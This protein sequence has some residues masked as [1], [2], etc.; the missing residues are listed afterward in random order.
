MLK[1]TVT[2]IDFNDVKQEETLYFNISKS[3]LLENLDI[4]DQITEIQKSFEG[5]ERE[6]TT[7]EKRA[8]LEL[9]KRVIRISYGERS[10]DGKRFNQKPEVW[11]AFVESAAYDEFLI[12]LFTNV[13]EA[14]A[15]ILGV[16]PA[17]LREQAAAK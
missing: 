13:D 17:D 5:P 3:T 2:Y 9:V 14:Y 10:A 11:E 12:S 8:I 15:F 7:A 16:M 6:L 1:K 4:Q